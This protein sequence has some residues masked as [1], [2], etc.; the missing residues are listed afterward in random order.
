MIRDLGYNQIGF[1]PSAAFVGLGNL[2]FLC[3]L[4]VFNGTTH[5]RFYSILGICKTI[6]FRPFLVG[7]SR[8]S[9]TSSTC[10]IRVFFYK[11]HH[12]CLVSQLPQCEQA[13][14]YCYRCT[15]RT[16]WSHQPV[17]LVRAVVLV[18]SINRTSIRDVSNN[19][20]SSLG[21]GSLSGLQNLEQLY[22]LKMI[23]VTS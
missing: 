9:A 16:Q 7:L 5:E 6:K 19:L 13:H 23:A 22:V 18:F 11:V 20:V 12:D 21:S 4:L 14:Y 1:V 3:V 8:D 15:Q 10:E 17:R 2:L